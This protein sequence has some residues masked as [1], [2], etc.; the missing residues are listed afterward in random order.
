VVIVTREF[1]RHRDTEDTEVAQRTQQC[2]IIAKLSHDSST[3]DLNVHD[4]KPG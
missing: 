1:L 2:F 3:E 4:I